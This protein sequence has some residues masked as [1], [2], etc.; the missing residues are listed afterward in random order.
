MDLGHQPLFSRHQ[1]T[2]T[3]SSV[4]FLLS[5]H[6]GQEFPFKMS[7]HSSRRTSTASTSSLP[8]TPAS[9]HFERELYSWSESEPG[10][11]PLVEAFASP[12]S[13][14]ESSSTLTC[15]S[16]STSMTPLHLLPRIGEEQDASWVEHKSAPV[17]ALT[18]SS[19]YPMQH[20]SIPRAATFH[21]IPTAPIVRPWPR[22]PQARHPEAPNLWEQARGLSIIEADSDDTSSDRERRSISPESESGSL[23]RRKHV[24]RPSRQRPELPRPLPAL[25]T[26]LSHSQST[27]GRYANLHASVSNDLATSDL[28][29]RSHTVNSLPSAV[30]PLPA[31]SRPLP[32][33][34]VPPLKLSTLELRSLPSETGAVLAKTPNRPTN[35]MGSMFAP[36]PMPTDASS[37]IDWD[38]IGDALEIDGDM[39]ATPTALPSKPEDRR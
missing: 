31:V 30:R 1:S 28:R 38:L 8:R 10:R 15:G 34:R 19:P 12:S 3:S 33:K 18:I 20:H 25:P 27:A 16:L 29:R 23:K 26:G 13:E 17:R 39:V 14:S 4:T 22:P 35:P 24:R 6:D 7:E 21:S 11:L 9:A 5:D 2:Y 36:P 37:Q 32:E